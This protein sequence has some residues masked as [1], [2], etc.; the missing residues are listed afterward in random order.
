MTTPQ[1]KK[2]IFDMFSPKIAKNRRKRR[3]VGKRESKDPQAPP[4]VNNYTHNK[5][6]V[7]RSLN[8]QPVAVEKRR[9]IPKTEGMPAVNGKS[10]QK[11]VDKAVTKVRPKVK[12]PDLKHAVIPRKSLK[13]AKDAKPA[14]KKTTRK[15][16]SRSKKD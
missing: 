11:L 10:G 1:K 2:Q 13:G 5:P 3:E 7:A 12:T 4:T 6:T 14:R 8:M 16:A 15:R 9:V